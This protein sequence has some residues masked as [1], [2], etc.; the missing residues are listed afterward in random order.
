M[1]LEQRIGRVD[2]IGQRRTVHAINLFARGTAEGTVLANLTR[3]LECIRASEIEV[4]ACCH[5]WSGATCATGSAGDQHQ[6]GRSVRT[7]SPGGMPHRSGATRPGSNNPIRW[8]RADHRPAAVCG[9]Q[10][11]VAHRIRA[12]PL[13][14]V[15]RPPR[16][17]HAAAGA[18]AARGHP[19]KAHSA[20]RQ[21][22]R[23]APDEHRGRN[24]HPRSDAPRRRTRRRDRQSIFGGD[25]TRRRAR[26]RD[27]TGEHCPQPRL[28][29]RADCSRAAHSTSAG[30][31]FDISTIRVH[32]P[33][34][35]ARLERDTAVLV[36]PNPGNR[37]APAHMLIGLSGSLVSH[38]FAE[39]V[40]RD[41]FAG[42]LGEA[43]AR[44]AF[45]RF[46][47]WW[48]AAS[49]QLGPASSIRA[50]WDVAAVP[51]AEQLGFTVTADSHSLRNARCAGLTAAGVRVELLA[52][53]WDESLDNLWRDAVRHAIVR[54]VPWILCTNGRQLR[55]VDGKRTYSRAYVQFDL[56]HAAAHIGTF[57]ILW[58]LLR[59]ESFAARG[60]A[61]P[62][63]AE[64]V[65][66]SA[67]HGEAVSRSLRHGVVEAVQHLLSGLHQ[68]ERRDLS[69]LFDESLTVVYRVLFLMFAESRGLVPSWHPVYRDSYTIESLRER[70]ER[71]G[72]SRGV[73]EALQA[74]ARLANQGCRAGTLFVPP[75]N[76]RLFSPARS[77]LAETCA[78]DDELAAKAV[79]AL[80]ATRERKQRTRI[81]YRDLGVEQLG[82]VY[83][84]ILDYEPVF[85]EPPNGVLLRRGG[86]ARKSTGSFYTPQSIT[87]YVVRR[88]LHPLVE[89]ATAEG[90][91]GLRVVDPAMGSGAFLVSA[92]RYL[93]RAY[94]R[95]LIREGSAQASDVRE[96]DRALFRRQ[97]AQRCLFGVD[98][99]PTAVQLARLSLWLATL[100]AGKPLTFLDHHLVTGDSLLGASPADLMRQPPGARAARA[101]SL[102]SCRSIPTRISSPRSLTR[103]PS[104]DGWRKQTMTRPTSCVRRRSGW[105]GYARTSSWKSIADLWCACWMW[106]DREQ[107]P[108]PAVFASLADKI[109]T[110]TSAL[111]ETVSARLLE[112]AAEI[113]RQRRFFHWTFEFPEAYFDAA[114]DSPP[115][116]RLRCRA[117]QSAVGHAAGRRPRAHVL[118]SLRHL[119]TSI[120][121]P[122]QPVP[123]VRRAR[124]DAG[125]ARRTHRSRA[126]FRIRDGS[127]RRT[128]E[129]HVAQP[130]RQSR[131]SPASTTGG[132]YSPSIEAFDSSSASPRAD[133]RRAASRAG[134]GSTTRASSKPSPMPAI[135]RHG[136]SHPISVT[137]AFL[138][139]LAG[140]KLAI[141][142]LRAEIDLRILDTHRAQ[143]SAPRRQRWLGCPVRAR[144][145]RHRRPRALPHG[146]E[147]YACPRGQTYRT[148]SRAPGA[149]DAQDL[150]P[151]GG[152]PAR[153][154]VRH[155]C[156]R[157]SPIATSQ[158][159]PI[160]SR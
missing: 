19:A 118:S 69:Q 159:R 54:D 122:H 142:E 37:V 139:A 71:P 49:A 6:H 63:I 115:Q 117:W 105:N 108:E 88:T 82:A 96:E 1:R 125:E 123:A 75:F 97:I 119:P 23:G 111:S 128:A 150:G 103:W 110:G 155:T 39:R 60:Q 10:R 30:K 158:A 120:G 9:L 148:V 67:R 34:D 29:F 25:S 76:G 66:S 2:R 93:A 73:W 116:R 102:A 81:D 13:H 140:D 89:D 53:T 99:N 132:R 85:A 121:R 57:N 151:P 27:S 147:R 87:D 72:E 127:R 145:E 78:V 26:A 114:G 64:L 51:L 136:P 134:S 21:T 104:A 91:M 38:H 32:D 31:R 33:S 143:R 157:G 8:R 109:R 36:A 154:S 5:P 68:C 41:E 124:A 98:L 46:A 144:V 20:R 58:A 106:P 126:A 4:A 50:I 7:G 137:P 79:A 95:A 62:L 28:S 83:E 61:I 18:T 152:R 156:A 84:S 45:S 56:K 70:V 47:R 42:R 35:A 90:I 77:P 146:Q 100:S 59:A 65:R 101:R 80:S 141:P 92:C 129:A 16:R 86:D 112:E 48:M 138:A 40:L 17:R 107:R 133:H 14:D 52:T 131:R 135:E 130:Y 153:C 160:G 24:A 15:N 113:A 55:L 12:H 43:T 22:H 3:R 94:E 11:C 149:L 44:I 74:I